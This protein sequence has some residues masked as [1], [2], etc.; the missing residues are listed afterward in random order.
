MPIPE[1]L[2][3]ETKDEFISRCIAEIVDEY[4]QKQAAAICYSKLS[5]ETK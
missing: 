1:R 5:R 2:P 4:G 3:I